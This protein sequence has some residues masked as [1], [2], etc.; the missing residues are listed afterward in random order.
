MDFR[1][2]RHFVAVCEHGTFHRAAQAVH[3]SQSA[4]SRSIQALEQELGVPLFDR[5]SQRIF[6]TPYGRVLLE[7]APRVLQEGRALQRELALLQGEDAGSLRLG[8]S[9]T[10]AAVLLH[11]CMVALLE[12]Y[13]RLRVDAVIGRTLELIEGLRR[14]HYDMV[15]LD[16]SAVTDV[17]GLD[18]EYLPVMQGDMLV[19]EGHPL[20]QLESLDFAAISQYPVACSVIS[21]DLTDRLIAEFGAQ[22]HPD[23]FVRFCC[24]S[25]SIQRDVVLDSDM[26]LMSVL[27]AVRRDIDAGDLVPLGFFSSSLSGH[28]ALVR[29]SGRTQL[30]ALDIVYDL[31]RRLCRA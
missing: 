16:V 30:P 8:L 11:P 24:D 3:L 25:F 4:L 26:V 14:E 22:G 20:L 1:K 7:R 13:P 21:D 12:E 18:I 9:S 15:V 31:A 27:A 23:S 10:P 29:L 17:R 28:Y 2:L 5:S 6:L 19:R